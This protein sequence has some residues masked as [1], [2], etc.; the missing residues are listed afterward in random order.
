MHALSC[1]R[2]EVRGQHGDKRLALAGLHLGDA[3]LMQHYAADELHPKR[4][5]PQHA[6]RRLAHG[7]ERLGQYVVRRLAVGK[8]RL[9]LV[10]LGAKLRIRQRGVLAVQLLYG[11]R[12]RV[13]PFQLPVGV[14]AE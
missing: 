7:G 6:P 11:V 8:T 12:Y 13:E 4:L 5:H 2:V 3:P 10:C 14:A 1:E 9:E